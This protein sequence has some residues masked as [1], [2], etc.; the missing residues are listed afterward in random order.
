VASKLLQKYFIAILEPRLVKT[1][2]NAFCRLAAADFFMIVVWLYVSFP[3]LSISLTGSCSPLF[4]LGFK[5]RYTHIDM[6]TCE[7]CNNVSAVHLD[8]L[9]ACPCHVYM[10]V[11]FAVIEVFSL[12]HHRI[13]CVH[14]FS[15]LSTNLCS[16][17]DSEWHFLISLNARHSHEKPL[18]SI[19]RQGSWVPF[20]T[21]KSTRNCC[22]VRT[23]N[24]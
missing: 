1:V 9:H 15:Q 14:T 4:V 20:A 24:L 19:D 17:K 16:Q 10:I 8:I 13:L 5:K 23:A 3:R 2:S 7:S 6:P 11:L 12:Y 21:R 18:K 22:H